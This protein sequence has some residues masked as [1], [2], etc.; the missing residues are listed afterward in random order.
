[1]SL[2]ISR[3]VLPGEDAHEDDYCGPMWWE[4][5]NVSTNNF[6]YWCVVYDRFNPEDPEH[7][8]RCS[9]QILDA[10]E[11]PFHAVQRGKPMGNDLTRTV[12]S[13][14]GKLTQD[15]KEGILDLPVQR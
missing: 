2:R 12:A 14:I 6:G 1:M 5:H 11:K 13:L 9:R 8:V 7:S 4:F 15:E 10:D 3:I